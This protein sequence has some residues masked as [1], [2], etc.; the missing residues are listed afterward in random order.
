MI[1]IMQMVA[2]FALWPIKKLNIRI[3]KT[4]IEG[5]NLYLFLIFL[6][7]FLTMGLRGIKV[8]SD[9]QTYMWIYESIMDS[10]SFME[11]LSRSTINSAPVYVGCQ[12][13]ISRLFD[14]KQLS[15]LINS[16]VVAFG[17][18][19]FIKKNSNNYLLSVF[20]FVALA[21]YFE[22]MNG[23]RQF[24]AV[25]IG[26]NAYELIKHNVKSKVG[27]L[28]FIISIGIHNIVIALGLAF[29]SFFIKNRKKSINNV[30]VY[31]FLLSTS[32]GVFASFGIE[33]MV[34]LFPYYN[35]YLNGVSS[36]QILQST[37]R[38]RIVLVY[39]FLAIIIGYSFYTFKN[40][41]KKKNAIDKDDLCAALICFILGVYFSKDFLLTR[42]LWP[43][44]SL[45]IVFIPNFISSVN[46]KQYRLIM[47]CLYVVLS[48]YWLMN[49]IENKS[50][51]IPYSFFWK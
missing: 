8:G 33:I 51:I 39:L 46:R 14:F 45:L 34:K 40:N 47:M 36:A 19:T 9:T 48:I 30:F 20:L 32:I 24:M 23:T 10:N 31:A 25:A 43:F 28:L 26:V 42:V 4:I 13:F 6:M 1:Y 21:L 44:L 29:I 16:F 7:F 12:Y 49:L 50:N 22:S 5:K 27:W 37:G 38:G 3:H 18:Y 41:I 2:V 17:F 11:A 15:I 35:I